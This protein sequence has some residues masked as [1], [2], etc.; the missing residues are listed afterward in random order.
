MKTQTV[1]LKLLQLLNGLLRLLNKRYYNI[2]VNRQYFFNRL[3]IYLLC[4]PKRTF[5]CKMPKSQRNFDICVILHCSATRLNIFQTTGMAEYLLCR[6]MMQ[7]TSTRALFIFGTGIRN[8]L[9]F[10]PTRYSF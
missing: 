1:I 9:R 2:F 8:L 6:Q 10:N 5:F 4:L 3:N 7:K